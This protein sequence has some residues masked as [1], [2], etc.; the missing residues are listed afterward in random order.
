M[1][2]AAAGAKA[3]PSP[4]LSSLFQL[5]DP[6]NPQGIVGEN[7]IENVVEKILARHNYISALQ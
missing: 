2:S 5:Q 7:Y 4:F 1:T 6:E 3:V